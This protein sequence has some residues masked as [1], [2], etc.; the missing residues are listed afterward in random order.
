[1]QEETPHFMCYGNGDFDFIYNTFYDAQSLKASA[2]LGY[3]YLDLYDVS[4]EIREHFYVNKTISLEKLAKHFDKNASEQNHNALDDAKLLKMVYEGI[5]KGKAEVSVFD[6]YLD[7]KRYPDQVR[8][9][10]RMNGD[11]ILDEFANMKEAVKW[12][13]SQP[14]DKGAQYIK[15]AEDKIKR[16]ARDGGRYFR[17]N[18]RIL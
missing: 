8:K 12:I 18:W 9:V 1:M 14:N 7:P 2:M 11:V 3:L 15:D 17:S 10:I 13:R 5:R 6:E 16:A 4:D